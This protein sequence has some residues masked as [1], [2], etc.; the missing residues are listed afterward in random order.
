MSIKTKIN[1]LK[2]FLKKKRII[3]MCRVF[4]GNE[5]ME[6]ALRNVEPY[7][8]KI[9]ILKS[10][11]TWNDTDYVADDVKPIIDRLNVKSGKY[12]YM[13]RDWGDQWQQQD[14]A[15]NL[16]RNEYPEATHLLF[17]DTDEI[18]EPAEMK[19]LAKYCNSI[20]YFNK[21]LR[22]NM[23][24]Y[25]KKVYYRV[26]PLEIYKPIAIVPLLDYVHFATIRDIEGAPKCIVDVYMH[27]FSLVMEDEKRLQMKFRSGVDDYVGVDNWY[28]KVY[29]PFDENS[30]NFHTL[31]GNE[32]QWASVEVVPSDKLPQGVEEIYK[33]WNRDD[34]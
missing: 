28:E 34:K 26:Y 5:W 20:K 4:Y 30:K 10:N 32:T 24:T 23:Y 27:H 19:K 18:Y 9:L 33:S 16:I 7:V 22:V 3:V 15:W 11:K 12:V 31:K 14:A 6:L 2:F 13:E 29:V 17:L 25:V 21:A 1:T 8:Y